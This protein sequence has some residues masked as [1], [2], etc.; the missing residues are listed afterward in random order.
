VQQRVVEMLAQVGAGTLE[1][2][3]VCGRGENDEDGRPGQGWRRLVGSLT[4]VKRQ[5]QKMRRFES[6]LALVP[7]ADQAEHRRLLGSLK[8]ARVLTAQSIRRIPF[9][10]DQW[11]E[12]SREIERS[13][14]EGDRLEQELQSA[15]AGEGRQAEIRVRVVRSQIRN[16]ENAAGASLGQ[17]RATLTRA[18]RGEREAEQAKVELVSANLRLVV[19]MA[20]RYMKRGLHLLDLVQEGNLGLMRAADKFDYRRGYKFSTYATWWIMQAVTRALSD[21]SRTI[22]LPVHMNDQLNKFFRASREL[23]NE[24]GRT[25]ADA[26]IAGRLKVTGDK[27][28]LLRSIAR[29]PV[30][31][32]M[33]IGMSDASSLGEMI[34]DTESASPA[35]TLF[36]SEVRHRTAASLATLIPR[37]AEVLRLRFGL[38]C[39]REHTL[40]EIGTSMAVTSE[41][42]R[43]IELRALR[44]L[45][46]P[47]S[48]ERLQALLA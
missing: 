17:Q 13:A 45:R 42:V 6:E 46:R 18:R 14:A 5:Y 47:E 44:K 21:Q 29:E 37:E 26:E 34:A 41:R 2:E 36:V 25:P 30:S 40:E 11:K 27:V 3:A 1:A 48:A 9:R 39:D 23:E 24:L 12:F 33:P 7:A 8:R 16:C 43:Q 35:D 38:G 10:A 15:Q 32:D 28:D 22:R 19:S 20:K 4:Q 31:L